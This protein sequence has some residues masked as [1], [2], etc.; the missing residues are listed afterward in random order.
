ME[1]VVPGVEGA[2]VEVPVLGAERVVAA[3]A[4]V[5]GTVDELSPQA[6]SRAPA[7]IIATIVVAARST[8]KNRVRPVRSAGWARNFHSTTGDG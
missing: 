7:I 4:L 5:R 3:E 2:G 8:A 6:P 1:G